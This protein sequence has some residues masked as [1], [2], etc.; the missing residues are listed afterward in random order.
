MPSIR[1]YS[2]G[3]STSS[4][5]ESKSRHSSILDAIAFSSQSTAPTSVSASPRLPESKSGPTPIPT[6]ASAT[7]SPQ[8]Q[9]YPETPTARFQPPTYE[10]PRNEDLS[11]STK[12]YPRLSVDTY[13][14]GTES[15]EALEQRLPESA[16]DS[17]DDEDEP[18]EPGHQSHQKHQ[19][20]SSSYEDTIPPLPEYRH[21][22]V[23][24]SVRP[25]T[26]HE[27]AQLFPS[28]NRMS[29]RHDEFTADGNMNLRVDIT[30]PVGSRRRPVSYQLFHLRMYDLA[31]REFSLRRYSRDSGREVCNSKLNF[32]DPAEKKNKAG[33]LSRKNSEE[34]NLKHWGHNNEN[35]NNNN[36]SSSRSGSNTKVSGR[37][38]FPHSMATALRSLGTIAAKP[39]FTRAHTFGSLGQQHGQR[40]ATSHSPYSNNSNKNNNSSH[41]DSED[42]ASIARPSSSSTP[43][44]F[45]R[46]RERSAPPPPLRPTNT[47]KLEFSNYARVDV[48]RRGG[49]GD[50][51]RYEFE[52]W[53]HKYAWKRVAEKHLNV[54]TY[55]LLRDDNGET[56]VAHIVPEMRSPNQVQA[57]EEAGG[58]IPPCHVWI[59]DPSVLEAM[60]DVGDVIISTGL[61]ALV[62]DSIR[63]RW[64]LPR[65][66][67]RITVPLT[68]RTLDM[69]NVYPRAL[70][71]HVF[72]RRNSHSSGSN[73]TGAG[74]HAASPL[75]HA[76]PIPTF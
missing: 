67:H 41:D 39:S 4:S 21:D 10:Q 56:P 13:V 52:W 70:M 57:D 27:F 19:R 54:V 1:Q 59:S 55:H 48:E 65:K 75:R 66:T 72:H 58:W 71:Q 30:V 40:P 63:T 20:H 53:G 18:H 64:W 44:F 22:I 60:T 45:G 50:H 61:M 47:I 37:P 25:S 32:V 5:R 26:P 9:N 36:N 12:C 51:T 7:I 2:S 14:S 42:V 35:N 69:D 3:N 31:K 17:S 28:L 11:P 23:D 8:P 62:D 73:H 38:T 49:D 24:G 68:S 29:I 76:E 16:M 6:P 43:S 74:T 15:E 33:R 34:H 46:S